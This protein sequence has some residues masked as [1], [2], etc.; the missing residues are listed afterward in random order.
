MDFELTDQQK[1]LNIVYAHR[2][3][4][5]DS[6]KIAYLR[7][8]SIESLTQAHAEWGVAQWILIAMLEAFGIKHAES[9]AYDFEA[10]D[11]LKRNGWQPED[12]EED[13]G[14]P[15]EYEEYQSQFE[16]IGWS[17]WDE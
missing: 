5:A 13:D 1:A 4:L 12:D 17:T 16:S 6:L 8:V 2:N 7:D 9:Y 10:L 3:N 14:Q 15:S 11:E